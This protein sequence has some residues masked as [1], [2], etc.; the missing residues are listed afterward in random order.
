MS[1]HNMMLP[2]GPDTEAFEKGS[3]A[4]QVPVKQEGTMAFMFETRYPQRVT[5]WAAGLPQLEH[6]YAD[7]WADL[8]KHFDPSRREPR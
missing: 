2:H 7:C 5:S 6:D 3:N 4:P 8:N 1:L